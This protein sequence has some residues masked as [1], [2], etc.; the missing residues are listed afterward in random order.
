MRLAIIPARGGSVRIPRKNIRDFQGK[1]MML[2]AIE[3][4]Q[5]ARVFDFIGVSTDDDEIAEMAMNFGCDV[6][7][8]PIDD[9][10]LGTQDVVAKV[11]R[12]KRVP[13]GASICTIYPCSPFLDASD[14]QDSYSIFD[15]TDFPVVATYSGVPT[16]A[17]C[18]Y[19]QRA[20]NLLVGAYVWD[21][22][23]V[24]YPL[25]ASRCIDINTPEDWARAEQMYAKLKEGQ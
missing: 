11:L 16:D 1:P 12:E 9:G 21:G 6:H 25:P 2:W 14:L 13:A 24:A 10:T 19:W 8:R 23:T 22:V 4:A 7:R 15:E 18:F 20:A 5:A 3:A 17:G